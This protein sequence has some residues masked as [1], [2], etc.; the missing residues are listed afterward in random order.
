MGIY[1][2]ALFVKSDNPVIATQLFGTTDYTLLS[3]VPPQKVTTDYDPASY[4]TTVKVDPPLAV[5]ET[6]KTQKFAF[7]GATGL[8]W[9][10]DEVAGGNSS[11]GTVAPDGTYRAPSTAP[12]RRSIS[13]NARNAAGDMSGGASIHVLQREEIIHGLA[14]VT[15]VAYFENAQRFFIAEQQVIAA[16]SKPERQEATTNAQIL[17]QRQDGTRTQFLPFNGDSLGKILPYV[18]DYNRNWLLAAGTISGKIYRINLDT[19]AQKEIAVLNKPNS[20][21]LDGAGDLLVAVENAIE[22]IPRA[23]LDAAEPGGG[24]VLQAGDARAGLPRRTVEVRSPR[25]IAVDRCSG[26]VYVTTADGTLWEFIGNSRRDVLAQQPRLNDPNEIFVVYVEGQSKCRE[27]LALLIC[28]SDGL[29]LVYPSLSRRIRFVGEATGGS[30]E[31]PRDL[32]Y[33]PAGNP[34]SPRRE[35]AVVIAENNRITAVAVGGLYTDNDPISDEER[36]FR[37]GDFPHPDPAGDTFAVESPSAGYR[38]PDLTSVDVTDLGESI[39]VTASFSEP[40]VK[41]GQGVANGVDILVELDVNGPYLGFPST[42]DQYATFGNT[43]LGYGVDLWIKS[44]TGTITEYPTMKETPIDIDFLENVVVMKIPRSLVNP[45]GTRLAIGVG[46]WL[47][48]TDIAPNSGH[49]AIKPPVVYGEAG[50][51][52]GGPSVRK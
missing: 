41:A 20:M 52:P 48:R 37:T 40:V 21:V 17:E 36:G 5:V 30:E 35:A 24:R 42:L 6:G 8:G 13:L 11:M 29:S 3:N 44:S 14:T 23:T 34:F 39:L 7:S 38:V 19:K 10:V 50:R 46:N 43:G 9:Y 45:S 16:P 26:A 22:V 51:E 32:Q 12:A 28:E 18:D 4:M 25:G 1:D 49:L 47:E 33:F 31:F 15:S 2:G 27:A